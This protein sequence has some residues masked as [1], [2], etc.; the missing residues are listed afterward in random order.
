MNLFHRLLAL[1]YFWRTLTPEKYFFKIGK[2]LKLYAE[3]FF[4]RVIIEE[5]L[6]YQMKWLD[7]GECIKSLRIIYL[8]YFLCEKSKWVIREYILHEI[9]HIYI[10]SNDHDSDFYEEYILLLRKYIV[11]SDLSRE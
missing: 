8:P 4:S 3:T 5:G 1:Y 2:E 10:G 9:A 7:N 6:N 11:N